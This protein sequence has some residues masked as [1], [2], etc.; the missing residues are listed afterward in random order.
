MFNPA[1]VR[2]I[3][4]ARYPE[5]FAASG[6]DEQLEEEESEALL[7]AV[8][9]QVHVFRVHSLRQFLQELALLEH[10]FLIEHAASLIVVDSIPSLIEKVVLL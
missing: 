4:L 6:D 9:A 2:D 7:D 1:R 10:S 3:A 8:L 5:V